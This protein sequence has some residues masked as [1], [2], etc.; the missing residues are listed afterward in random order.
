MLNILLTVLYVQLVPVVRGNGVYQEGMDFLISKLQDGAWVHIYPE[1][2]CALC[3][4]ML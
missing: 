2:L 3:L 1:G 4:G